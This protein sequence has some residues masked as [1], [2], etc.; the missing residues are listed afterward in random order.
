MENI[1]NRQGSPY[2]M[3]RIELNGSTQLAYMVTPRATCV[4]CVFTSEEE[5]FNVRFIWNRGIPL[6]L[7]IDADV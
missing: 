3:F 4:S 7:L 6:V 5:Q 1:K 2:P